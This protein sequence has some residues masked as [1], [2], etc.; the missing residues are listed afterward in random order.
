M[1]GIQLS[2][3]IL[4]IGSQ[5]EF[6]RCLDGHKVVLATVTDYAQAL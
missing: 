1:F 4:Y 3:A 5:I 6:D 2:Q